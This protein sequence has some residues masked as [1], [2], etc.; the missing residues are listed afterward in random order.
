MVLWCANFNVGMGTGVSSNDRSASKKKHKWTN[1][2][3]VLF[4][5][6]ETK[7]EFSLKLEQVG[8]LAI[9]VWALSF[10]NLREN[11]SFE[12]QEKYG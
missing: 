8:P 12:K 9:D 6:S 2:K 1:L 10:Q 11:I 3:Q 7:L 5:M 4:E